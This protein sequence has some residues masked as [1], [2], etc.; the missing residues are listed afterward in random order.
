MKVVID[1]N[2]VVAA[3]IKDSTTRK[4]LFDGNFEFVAPDYIKT[5]IDKY[6]NIITKKAEITKN[7]FDILLSLI[8]E[9]ISIIPQNE[10]NKFIADFKGYLNDPK[11]LAYIATSAATKAQGVWTH[12][13]HFKVQ[14]KVK[15]FTNKDL[16][17]M[18][19]SRT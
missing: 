12:D 17:E 13:L 2:R 7:E 8:F 19:N 9:N 16:L 6:K 4:I 14:G 5:E 1:A 18:S 3:L 11:D 10:Y 15:I